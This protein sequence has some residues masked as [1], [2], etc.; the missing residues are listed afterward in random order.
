[1]ECS[2][3]ATAVSPLDRDGRPLSLPSTELG[4]TIDESNGIVFVNFRS[5]CHV[6]VIVTDE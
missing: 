2:L 5:Q 6:D 4:K 3:A 1:M